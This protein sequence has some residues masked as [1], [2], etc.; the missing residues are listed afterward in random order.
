MSKK[1]T[2]IGE[3]GLKPAFLRALAYRLNVSDRKIIDVPVGDLIPNLDHHNLEELPGLGLKTIARFRDTLKSLGYDDETCPFLRQR[4]KREARQKLEEQLRHRNLSARDFDLIWSVA[5][6]TL[7]T[8]GVL[9]WVDYL[10]D[11]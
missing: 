7:R 6:E 4:T 2:T 3:L 10:Y 8:D 1:K 9:N 5:Q 11:E